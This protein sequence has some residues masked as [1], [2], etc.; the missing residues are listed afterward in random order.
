MIY[1][2]YALIDP[3]TMVTFYV[4]CTK[5]PK[6]RLREHICR[7]QTGNAHAPAALRSYILEILNAG[8]QP[9]LTVLEQTT[10]KMRERHW[11][12]HCRFLG[13][14][15][16]NKVLY[17]PKRQKLTPAEIAAIKRASAIRTG[18]AKRAKSEARYEE[19]KRTQGR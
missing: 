1:T 2:V 12:D 19:Y 10:D 3:R 14:P 17:P 13:L 16:I 8:F 15:I 6:R 11:I 18:A 7:A 9:S 5:N 4:G